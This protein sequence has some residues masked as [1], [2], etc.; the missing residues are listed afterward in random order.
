MAIFSRAVVF[1]GKKEAS[2][3]DD[4]SSSGQGLQVQIS[5]QC[6]LALLGENML[7]S[8]AHLLHRYGLL[9]FY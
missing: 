4:E 7:H 3:P 9:S 5:W 1:S 2:M 8:A 6:T